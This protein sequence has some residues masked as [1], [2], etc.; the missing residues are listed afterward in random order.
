MNQ[1]EEY[2]R[3][4]DQARIHYEKQLFSKDQEIEKLVEEI[5]NFKSTVQSKDLHRSWRDAERKLRL[6]LSS[7]DIKLK[8]LKEAIKSLEDK[9]VEALKKNADE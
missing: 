4:Q 9:L 3:K 6:Q 8:H 7:K 5:E 1:V 2:T